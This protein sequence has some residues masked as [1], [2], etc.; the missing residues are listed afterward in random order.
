MAAFD[1]A[2]AQVRK[3]ADDL[4]LPQRINQL[5]RRRGISFRDTPLTP[6]NTLRLFV[7]QV[8]HGNVACT[9]MRHL[10]GED[11]SDSAWCQARTRLPLEL[12]QEVHRSILEVARR[13]GK[14]GEQAVLSMAVGTDIACSA[15]MA[16]ATQCPT[17]PE[18]RTTTGSLPNCREG[19]GFPTSH[20]LMLMDHHSG[21]VID[22]A[23]SPLNTSDLS[24]TPPMHRH[25]QEGDILLAD[26]AFSGWAHLALILQAHLHAVMPVHQR[27][28][29]DF[30]PAR[31]M[32]IRAK[33]PPAS[34]SASRA[35][36]CSRRSGP[37]INWWST[38]SPERN[39]HG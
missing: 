30:D 22:C 8:A 19:L 15:S 13:N 20:L 12:I 25:L 28:I 3:G 9:A 11:F 6:G 7:Q 34:V 37:R 16:P 31:S 5:A 27:R 14:Y 4:L 35:P 24:Q 17:L 23:D 36:A 2:L 10:A 26:V 18:L 1:L 21:L 29:V 38:S 32:P 39:P 33:R